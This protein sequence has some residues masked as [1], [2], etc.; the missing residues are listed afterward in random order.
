MARA[1]AEFIEA[2]VAGDGKEPGGKFGGL[3]V[4]TARFIDLQE[5]VLSDVFGLG[6]VVEIAEN[7]IQDFLFVLIHEFGKSGAVAAFH[8]EHEGGVGVWLYGRFQKILSM[9]RKQGGNRKMELRIFRAEC[10]KDE[11]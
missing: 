8:A 11:L 9:M 4:A 10:L 2:E 5:D 7:E 1:T 3:P 6:L